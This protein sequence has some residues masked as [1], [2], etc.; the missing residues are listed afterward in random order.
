MVDG[1]TFQKDLGLPGLGLFVTSALIG[2]RIYARFAPE[3]SRAPQT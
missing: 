3:R 1:S 2:S